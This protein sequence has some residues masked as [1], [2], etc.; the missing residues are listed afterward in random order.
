[1]YLPINF[2]V[3]LLQPLIIIVHLLCISYISGGDTCQFPW[4][5]FLCPL[6]II[7]YGGSVPPCRMLMHLLCLGGKCNGTGGTAL[8]FRKSSPSHL[9][10]IGMDTEFL[11]AQQSEDL[12]RL[13][14]NPSPFSEEEL[15][16]FTSNW[17]V[18]SIR[19]HVL[20]NAPILKY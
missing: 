3:F 14:G 1:M 17:P 4:R 2:E 13:S 9:I 18:W 20:L 15:K 19:A 7:L 10:L 6:T 11:T 16:D 12:Q 8:I 5:A